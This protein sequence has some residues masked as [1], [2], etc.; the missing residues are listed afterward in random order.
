[1][2]LDEAVT[3]IVNRLKEEGLFDNTLFIIYGDHDAYYHQSATNPGLSRILTESNSVSDI[4]QYHTS[5]FF[6]NKKLTDEYRKNYGIA[7]NE[8]CEVS[9]F[10][11]PYIIVPTVLDLLGVDYETRCYYSLSYFDFKTKY[12]GLFYSS[13]LG[14]FFTDLMY[15]KSPGSYSYLDKELTKTDIELI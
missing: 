4:E 6:Y 11:S 5:L 8:P 7:S 3:K 15:S 14:A 9:D 1:M 10:V 2:N 13:E 12:D